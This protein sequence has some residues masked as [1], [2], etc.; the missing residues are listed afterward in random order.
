[1]AEDKE[2]LLYSGR[3]HRVPLGFRLPL[4]LIFLNPKRNRGQDKKKTKV[5]DR[6]VNCKPSFWDTQI[7]MHSL[8]PKKKKIKCL[9]ST[10]FPQLSSITRHCIDS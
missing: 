9:F 7:H 6:E 4:S 2:R 1:M 3:P 5:L 10:H 8:D